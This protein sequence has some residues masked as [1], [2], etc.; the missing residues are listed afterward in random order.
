M[1]ALNDQR[2]MDVALALSE[3]GRGRTAPNPNVGC[4]ILKAG[5]VVGRGWT[6]PSGRPHAEAMA[7]AQA[8][9]AA[10]GGTAY[11]TLEPCAHDS[12]RGPACADSLIAAG[13][14]RVVIALVDPDP[15]TNGAG[16]AKLEAA[17]IA[18]TTGLRAA[19]ARATMAGFLTRREKG[20][21]FVTLKLATSLDGRIALESGESKWITGPEARAHAH[22]ERARHEAILV[23]RG[24]W[25]AD[26]PRLDVRLAGLEDRSP[27]P[28]ILSSSGALR[29]P[30]AIAALEHVDHLFVEGGAQVAASFLRA[31]LV[32]RLLLYRAP[33]IIGAGKSALGDIGLDCLADAHGRW[34]LIDSRKLGMDR[35]EVYAAQ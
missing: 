3:R 2:W 5:V 15:R 26:K 19:E 29:E 8:G 20:R 35:L 27:R 6:Q 12:P 25:E 16:I 23:G 32:D 11:V 30:A 34:K 1:G 14:Q 7:L 31:D 22:L 4:V 21:P 33:I 18:V 10:R 9:D 24:T 13:L 28:I 17:G